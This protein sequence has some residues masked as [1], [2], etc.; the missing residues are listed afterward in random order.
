M[1][2]LHWSVTSGKICPALAGS[3]YPRA[4]AAPDPTPTYRRV[5]ARTRA[6]ATVDSPETES[7]TL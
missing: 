5:R 1:A 6:D 2:T 3:T 7:V 4:V